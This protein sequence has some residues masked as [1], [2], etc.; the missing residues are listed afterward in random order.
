MND[1]LT[2]Q[3]QSIGGTPGMETRVTMLIVA[4]F[5]FAVLILL[6]YFKMSEADKKAGI[7]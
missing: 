4:T 7:Q 6:L 2:Q 1:T 5:L 3:I